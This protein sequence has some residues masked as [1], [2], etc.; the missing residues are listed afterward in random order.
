MKKSFFIAGIVFY[1]L[2]TISVVYACQPCGSSLNFEETAAKADLII[3]GQRTDFSS[4]EQ[5]SFSNLPDSI[6]VKIFEILKGDIKQNEI[7]INSWNGMCGYGITVD[8]AIYVM[9][10]QEKVEIYDAIDSGCSIK[11]YLIEDDKVNFEGKKIL[12]DEFV[13]K[14]GPQA[15]RQVLD[16]KANLQFSLLYFIIPSALIILFFI[17]T[18]TRN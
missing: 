17:M 2:I 13:N 10:L 4:N 7:I 8:D 16:N 3:I 6:N 15:S 11:T 5:D 9:F 12:I 18:K 14:L 1:F